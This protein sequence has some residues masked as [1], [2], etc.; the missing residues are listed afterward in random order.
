MA[1]MIAVEEARI[2][3][4]LTFLHHVCDELEQGGCPV[5]VM[6]SLDH[7]PDLGSDLDLYTTADPQQVLSVMLRRLGAHIEARSW[8]D[9]LANKWNFTIPGLPESIEIHA[10]RLGQTGEH[11]AMAKRF[12]TR[13]VPKTVNGLTFPG[14]GAGGARRGG[15]AAAHVSPFL[16]P[17][18]RHREYAEPAEFRPARFR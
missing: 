12:V 14:A 8:G 15:H 10:Q 11:L 3:N 13:R 17:G 1:A 16:L 5:A 2:D 7:W 6:K 18:V 4:A 9:R